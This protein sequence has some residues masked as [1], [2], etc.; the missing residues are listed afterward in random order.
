MCVWVCAHVCTFMCVRGFYF[1]TS[2]SDLLYCLLIVKGEVATVSESASDLETRP[3]LC[4]DVMDEQTQ[5]HRDYYLSPDPAALPGRP[6]QSADAKLLS[7][8]HW[9]SSTDM[10]LLYHTLSFLLCPLLL[11]SFVLALLYSERW[12]SISYS[13]A[14]ATKESFTVLSMSWESYWVWYCIA[15]VL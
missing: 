13:W 2:H 12:L 1:K 7:A 5:A 10:L 15:W 11:Q 14:T 6:T 9:F 3:V 8:S 4:C